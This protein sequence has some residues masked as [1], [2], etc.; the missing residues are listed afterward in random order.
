[1]ATPTA[2]K[3][4]GMHGLLGECGVVK[5]EEQWV[6]RIGVNK[7]SVFCEIISGVILASSNHISS[8]CCYTGRIYSFLFCCPSNTKTI[9]TYLY[10][11]Y[12]Q[13]RILILMFAHLRV[14]MMAD[15]NLKYPEVF[16]IHGSTVCL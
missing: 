3:C 4:L 9:F 1:M 12:L 2:Y 13:L 5:A 10:Y 7:R 14:A 15:S 6:P 11:K 8:R 16:R